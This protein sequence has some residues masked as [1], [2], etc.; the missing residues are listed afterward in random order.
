MILVLGR[1]CA[2]TET[3]S[4]FSTLIAPEEQPNKAIKQFY[5]SVTNKHFY[6]LCLSITEMQKCMWNTEPLTSLPEVSSDLCLPFYH[7]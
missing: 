5:E 3:I 4:C 6:D 7:L 2:Q 1:S